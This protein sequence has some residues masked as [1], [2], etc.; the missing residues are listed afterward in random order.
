MGTNYKLNNNFYLVFIECIHNHLFVRI[1]SVQQNCIL[2][3]LK[4]NYLSEK[5]YENTH[6][7]ISNKILRNYMFLISN[8]I[9]YFILYNPIDNRCRSWYWKGISDW[10]CI[11]RC[12]SG[13]LGYSSRNEYH[14]NE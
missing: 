9:R 12:N 14:N 11:F 6:F 10:L 13:V 3:Y 7:Q 2:L 4:Y 8:I 5:C 1:Y